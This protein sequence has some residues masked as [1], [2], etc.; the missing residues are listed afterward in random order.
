MPLSLKWRIKPYLHYLRCHCT[1]R[2]HVGAQ[3]QDVGIVVPAAH[4]CA[5]DVVNH[6]GPNAPNLVCG[7][8]HAQTCPT[9]QNAAVTF[10]AYNGPGYPEGVVRKIGRAHV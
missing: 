3:T 6:Y 9:H 4:L 7:E 1:W 2:N 8:R 10:F 5:E